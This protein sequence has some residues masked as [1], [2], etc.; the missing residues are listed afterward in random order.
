MSKN[1]LVE[2]GTEEMPA[3]FINDAV[4]QLS[5][6]LKK[7]LDE[8]RVSYGDVK[9]Y[10]TPR[11][12]TV[13]INDVAEKQEDR[14]EELRGPAIKIAK[15]SEG[16]WTKAAIG[17][18]KGQGLSV[19]DLYIKAIKDIDY[20]FLNK[21]YKG[22]EV[23]GLL[24]AVLTEIIQGMTFPKNMRWGAQEIRYVRPIRWILTLF[25]ENLIPVEFVGIKSSFTTKG[26]RF[27]GQ[28]IE[29]T[30]INEYEAKLKEQYVIVD[31]EE[32]E[33]IILQQ[34]AKLE[35]D[36]GWVIPI[37]KGLLAEVVNLVEYPTALFG[38]FKDEY[39]DLPREVLVT[40]MKEHQRYFAVEDK[41]G[42]LLPYFVTVRNG[43][44]RSLDIVRKG[45]EKVLT[46]RLADA[47]FFYLEDQQLQISEALSKLEHIVFQEGLGTIG[48]KVRRIKEISKF[49]S[50]EFKF[51]PR[52]A[53]EVNRTAEICKFDLVTNMVYEFPELQGL[54]GEKYARLH[55]ESD[56]IAKGI[57]EHYLPR[58][59]G[60]MLPESKVGQVVSIA[61]KID[62]IIGSFSLGKIPTGSQDPLGLR[63]QAAGIVQILLDKLPTLE[64]GLLFEL[65]LD[66]YESKGLLNRSRDEITLDLYDFFTLRIK[67]LLQEKGIRYDIIE[68]ALETDKNKIK[69]IVDKAQTLNKEVEEA[70]FK[71]TVDSFTRVMNIA[72]KSNHSSTNPDAYIEEVEKEL[73]AQYKQVV[74]N[75]KKL[76][77]SE[78][79]LAELKSLKEPIDKYFDKVMIMVEDDDLRQQRL[80]LMLSISNLI[81]SYADFSKLVFA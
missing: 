9:L 18:A 73:Y 38:S 44:N 65:S 75:I 32:R 20:V 41:E 15:D 81:R 72:T 21:E 53:N 55:G 26:H 23:E 47:R 11:R 46:A 10:S 22:E 5:V 36:H 30:S 3:R 6:K 74:E 29:I 19:D 67:N 76:E 66:A 61:D 14:V 68:A 64:L 43:N 80:G 50:E 33:R 58:F 59:S 77:A 25:G 40:T 24:P 35:Q 13:L 57:F 69:L 60:D 78:A 2:I 54:M 4:T 45:N 16:N 71:A 34:I 56:A 31:H 8:S 17:F 48:D 1:L 49:L 37:D 39:L 70:E 63:R 28:D 62:N 79:I 51:D 12:L 27:L 7:W 42:N 52:T